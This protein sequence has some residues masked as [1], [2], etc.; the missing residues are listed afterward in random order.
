MIVA[1][2]CNITKYAL[3]KL[4]QIQW[5][6]KPKDK[7]GDDIILENYL[8][9]LDCSTVKPYICH[10][11]NC[12]NE[13]II[14]VCEVLVE[15]ITYSIAEDNKTV[16]FSVNSDAITGATEP[17]TYEWT[18]DDDDFILASPLDQSLLVLTLQDSKQFEVLVSTVSV[19]IT[20]VNGCTYTKV[21][22]F[23]ATV[24]QCGDYTPCPN[25]S[26]L[27]IINKYVQCA[28]PQSLVVT[29]KV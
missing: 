1:A 2:K 11:D 14:L 22:Y 10:P 3:D 23:V 25:P 16:T 9:Y 29:K 28:G 4:H 26:N 15:G 6:F 13:T 8:E 18:F 27:Q 17:L 19:K 21:C 5:G 7:I 20:D 24:M 12:V